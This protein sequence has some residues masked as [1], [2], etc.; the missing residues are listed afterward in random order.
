MRTLVMFPFVSGVHKSTSHEW[1]IDI[2]NPVCRIILLG[3][4]ARRS[5]VI[6]GTVISHFIDWSHWRNTYTSVTIYS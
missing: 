1:D 6:K 5:L 3:N 2:N 4:G